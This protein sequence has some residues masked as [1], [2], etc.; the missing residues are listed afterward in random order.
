MEKSNFI[1]T[2]KFIA[3]AL[4]GR[5]LTSKRGGLIRI[6]ALKIS[7]LDSSDLCVQIDGEFLPLTSKHLEI[8]VL[9]KKLN[10]IVP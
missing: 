3:N 6:S 5:K 9:P 10:L 1:N 8:K 4:T 7:L 2:I